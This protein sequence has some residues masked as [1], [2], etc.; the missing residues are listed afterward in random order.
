MVKKGKI[1]APPPLMGTTVT[2]G[3]PSP[4]EQYLESPLDLN[5]LLVKRP[6]ATFFVRAAGDS[7]IGAGIQ[8][9]DVL[10]VDRSLEAVD[11]AVIIASVDNE[12]TVK[13]LKKNGTNIRLEAANR[14]YKPIVFD[15]EMELRIFGVVT[16]VIHQF[17][18]NAA[19]NSVDPESPTTP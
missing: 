14:R 5:E 4:A 3:F 11:G 1:N 8:S 6:A 2:A 10:V 18:G 13:Y 16:A 15:G 19:R 9:G 7:M 12:F 17:V